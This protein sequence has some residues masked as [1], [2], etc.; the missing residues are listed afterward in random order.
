MGIDRLLIN[1]KESAQKIGFRQPELVSGSHH[2]L[3]IN[4]MGF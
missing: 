3:S 4:G 1:K 2:H